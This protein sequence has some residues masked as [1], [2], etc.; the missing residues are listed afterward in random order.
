MS[1]KGHHAANSAEQRLKDL[2]R[3]GSACNTRQ[4]LRCFI[5]FEL[6]F[7]WEGG[8]GMVCYARR[9]KDFGGDGP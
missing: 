7:V 5:E 9:R 3:C 8:H 1:P 4:V 6:R 2:E